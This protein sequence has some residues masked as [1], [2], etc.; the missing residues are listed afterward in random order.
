MRHSLGI[1]A[2]H[3][4][5][6]NF[7]GVGKDVTFVELHDISE[8][9]YPSHKPVHGARFD[10]MLPFSSHE[11]FIKDA[12][13]RRRAQFHGGLHGV[14]INWMVAGLPG[15]LSNLSHEPFRV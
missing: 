13:E 12:L 10:N 11:F 15:I 8:V 6:L 9:V 5:V 4:T 2:G 14:A 3:E 1:E 7:V